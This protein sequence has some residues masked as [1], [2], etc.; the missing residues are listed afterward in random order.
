MKIIFRKLNSE[1]SFI[2]I[3]CS[4]NNVKVFNFNFIYTFFGN[5]FCICIIALNR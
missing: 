1:P 5:D 2:K 4:L 3:F